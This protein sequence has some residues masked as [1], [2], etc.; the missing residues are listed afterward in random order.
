MKRYDKEKLF[1]MMHKMAG[2][3]FNENLKKSKKYKYLI[4]TYSGEDIVNKKI[5]FLDKPYLQTYDNDVP[6]TLGSNQAL[7][8][9]G[10]NDND[11]PT[12]S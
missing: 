7:I 1:E 8:Y 6:M 4:I 11:D 10:D 2:M 9:I 3:S 12:K 5:V